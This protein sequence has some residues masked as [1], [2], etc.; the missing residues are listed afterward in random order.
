MLMTSRLK[1]RFAVGEDIRMS[2]YDEGSGPVLLLLHG[3]TGSKLDFHDQIPFFSQDYRVIAPDNRGHGESTNTGDRESY[4]LDVLAADLANLIRHLG[5]V[6]IH[7]LGHS[8]GGMVVM[9]YLPVS[10]GSVRSLMLMDTS[11]APLAMPNASRQ[12]FYDALVAGDISD[13]VEMMKKLPR[14][15]EVQNGVDELGEQE[16]WARIKEK[17]TQMD[18]LAFLGLAEQLRIAED[19][20]DSLASVSIPALVIVGE[21]DTPFLEPS[22]KMSEVLPDCELKIINDAAHCP[23]YENAVRWREVVRA[24]LNR[25]SG[26]V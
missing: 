5:L 14:S 20:T 12:A 1:S 19:V 21:T 17:L 13:I 7:L 22:K 24:H 25:A 4:R 2:Y 18:P 9:R 16:H 15:A 11:S 3:F 10:E 26:V 8:M 23:Q 6:N